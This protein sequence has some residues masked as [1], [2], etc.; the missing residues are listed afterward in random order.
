MILL[1]F[2]GSL[3]LTAAAAG[4]GYGLA[5]RKRAVWEQLH[6]FCALLE[7]L[8]AGIQFR[9]EPCAPLL[10]GA[11]ADPRFATLALESCREF[12]EIRPPPALGQT[13]CAEV[14][15]ALAEL[16]SAPRQRACAILSHL[17][18]QCQAA[19]RAADQAASEAVRLY[20]RLG[21]CAGLAAALL[22]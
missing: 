14:R 9:A 4:M 3:L 2:W 19:E 10:A 18:L 6:A 12:S 1:R 5:L 11:A 7:Y 21:L 15:Q 22:L 17:L 20:P 13:L 16:T 8:R